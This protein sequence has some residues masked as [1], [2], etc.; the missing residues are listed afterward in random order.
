MIAAAIVAA[1]L[2]APPARATDETRIATVTAYCSRCSLPKDRTGRR[3]QTGI[4]S[5]DLR[6]HPMGQRIEFGWPLNRTL[7]VRDIG[8]KIR[9]RDRFDLCRGTV[10]VCT[11][12]DWGRRRVRYRVVSGQ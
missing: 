4:V 2:S 9:G 12:G 1:V 8:G 7:V 11:C 3:L 10:D 6:Y 5:A